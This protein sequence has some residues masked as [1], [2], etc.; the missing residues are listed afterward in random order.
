[1][2]QSN[3]T[4]TRPSTRALYGWAVSLIALGFSLLYLI[5]F[6]AQ[7]TSCANGCQTFYAFGNVVRPIGVIL[8]LAGLGLFIG[9]TICLIVRKLKRN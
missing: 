8:F 2:D 7:R 1:M 9:N 6:I 5:L 4:K 3:I